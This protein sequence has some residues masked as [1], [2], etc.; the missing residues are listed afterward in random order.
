[1]FD[2]S[3]VGGVVAVA[4]IIFV[5]LIGWHLI[6]MARRSKNA[7]QDLFHIQEY[8]TEVKVP[9]GSKAIGKS[10]SE[11]ESAT[12]DSDVILAHV[13][14]T[15]SSSQNASSCEFIFFI[16]FWQVL[17]VTFSKP[18]SSKIKTFFIVQ[19]LC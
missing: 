2:F 13:T 6:P 3:P 1:M 5:A 11:L 8:L 14:V 12:E 17:S 9:E 4:G 7:P 10:L 16:N 15:V 19:S 18:S